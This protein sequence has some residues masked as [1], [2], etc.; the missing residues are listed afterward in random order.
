[1]RRDEE[2]PDFSLSLNCFHPNNISDQ[3]TDPPSGCLLDG[4]VMNVVYFTDG[5]ALC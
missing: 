2:G 5:D 4:F 3:I 1:M